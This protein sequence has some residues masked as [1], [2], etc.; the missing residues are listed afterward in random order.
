MA[1][2]YLPT[3][4]LYRLNPLGALALPVAGMLYLFITLDSARLHWLGKGAY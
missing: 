4:R 3:L 1:W 2:T